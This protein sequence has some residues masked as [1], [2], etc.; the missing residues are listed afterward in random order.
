M[1]EPVKLYRQPELDHPALIVSWTSDTAGLSERVS[2]YLNRRLNHDAFCEIEPD[3]FF[4]LEGV[5]IEND[6][7]QF[8]DCRFFAGSRKDIVIFE[9]TPPRFEWYRFLNLVLDVARDQCNVR[10]LY[11][12]GGMASL[13]AHTT[14]REILGNFNSAEMKDSLAGYNLNT[15]LDYETPPGQRPTLNSF[16]LWTAQRRNEFS[17]GR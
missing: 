14:P 8:P 3:E 16:L 9:S 6:I 4:P 11:A 13:A 5:A 12:I 15:A 2:G 17:V 7:V 1:S 10:E